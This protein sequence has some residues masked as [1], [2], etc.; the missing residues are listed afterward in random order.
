MNPWWIQ[1]FMG[2]GPPLVHFLIHGYIKAIVWNLNASVYEAISLHTKPNYL[3]YILSRLLDT[4]NI[5]YMQLYICNNVRIKS[6]KR[7]HLVNY[8]LAKP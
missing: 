8:V 1:G 7:Y 6:W 4:S 5:I 2:P 3:V